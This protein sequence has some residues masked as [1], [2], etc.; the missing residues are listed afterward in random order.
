MSR[1]PPPQ[2]SERWLRWHADRYLQ[3]WF[4]TAHHL[5]RLLTRRALRSAEHHG[6]DPHEARE[7]VATV[8]DDLVRRGILDDRVWA[9]GRVRTLRQRGVSERLIRAK[10]AEKGLWGEIVDE[11][12]GEVDGEDESVDPELQAAWTYARKRRL[13]PYRGQDRAEQRQRDLAR[14]GRRG[15]SYAVASRVVDA[16]APPEPQHEGP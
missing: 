4:T 7:L 14:L 9:R 10:L 1:R 8:V 13:G 15:F 11:V 3:R 6:T 16:E 5:R 2:V 12:L